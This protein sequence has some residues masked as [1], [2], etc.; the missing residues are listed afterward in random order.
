MIKSM[1]SNRFPNKKFTSAIFCEFFESL[2]QE[3]FSQ[4]HELIVEV[5]NFK[6]EFEEK[7]FKRVMHSIFVAFGPKR[8]L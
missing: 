1:L 5:I 8:I 2:D 7:A 3:A 6:E 4:V